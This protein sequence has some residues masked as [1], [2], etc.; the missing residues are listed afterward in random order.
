MEEVKES[1]SS[2]F[3]QDIKIW[4]YSTEVLKCPKRYISHLTNFYRDATDLSQVQLNS[5]IDRHG[6]T[7]KT[8]KTIGMKKLLNSPL[9]YCSFFDLRAKLIRILKLKFA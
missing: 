1:H 4:I 5:L 9:L 3:M 2:F 7:R 8:C 6:E